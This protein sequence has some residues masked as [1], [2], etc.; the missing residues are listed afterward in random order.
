[1]DLDPG[2]ER[3]TTVADLMVVLRENFKLAPNSDYFVRSESAGKQLDSFQ[4]LEAAGV[5]DGD[6]L[7]VAP[8]LQAG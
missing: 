5:K 2:A 4:T 8:I 7:E 1:L 6:V 3:T